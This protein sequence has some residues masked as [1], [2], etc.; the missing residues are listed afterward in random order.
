MDK[1]NL[2]TM[3]M[4]IIDSDP[5]GIKICRVFGSSL[6]TVV[7]P[8]RLLSRA[9]KL[10]EI[11]HRGIYYLLDERHGRLARVYAG[12]TTQSFRRI[13]THN[14]TKDWWNKVVMFLAP[15][16]ELSLDIVSGLEAVAIA[17]IREHG[18]YEVENSATPD[19]SISPYSVGFI[20]D[21]HNE[22]L[23]RMKVLGFD[24]DAVASKGGAPS[25]AVFHTRRRGVK[26]LGTYSPDDGVFTVLAGSEI[27]M[28]HAPLAR[29]GVVSGAEKQ[30]REL[31]EQGL[32]ALD[33]VGV[34]RLKRGVEFAS[35]S[36][37][38]IFVFGG[39][40]NGWTEWID[41]EGRTLSQVYREGK[42]DEQNR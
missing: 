29:E 22:I 4:Q 7:V 32:I 11:P 8:R 12:Q 40:A 34:Y 16:N 14:S 28:S 24:L 5:D 13:D 15:D 20:D 17:Y 33:D 36:T 2:T 27:D 9:K 23:F 6:I 35:P 10:P 21:L 1:I 39:S 19:P 25:R 30:R 37:A 42:A 18:S 41:A 26:G 3:T 38:A 31:I